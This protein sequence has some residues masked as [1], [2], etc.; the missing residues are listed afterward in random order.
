ME[1]KAM[2]QKNLSVL[3]ASLPMLS[4]CYSEEADAFKTSHE[5]VFS[6]NVVSMVDSLTSAIRT[7]NIKDETSAEEIIQALDSYHKKRMAIVDSLSKA[8]G[9]MA[10]QTFRGF[11]LQFRKFEL[12]QKTGKESLTKVL[13][14]CSDINL[15]IYIQYIKNQHIIEGVSGVSM[16]SGTYVVEEIKVFPHPYLEKVFKYGIKEEETYI[17][18]LIPKRQAYFF[19]DIQPTLNVNGQAIDFNTQCYVFS[20]KPTSIGLHQYRI[21]YKMSDFKN[22][23]FSG[24]GNCCYKVIPK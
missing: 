14:N 2:L 18:F 1:D 11:F 22:E 7:F 13:K 17:A 21:S 19:T 10:E 3:E 20:E 6:N 9:E 15:R 8:S 12:N 24:G 16:M 4:D 23:N 5:G